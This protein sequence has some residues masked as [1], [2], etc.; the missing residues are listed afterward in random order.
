MVGLYL[1]QTGSGNSVLILHMVSPIRDLAW[2][3]CSTSPIVGLISDAISVPR[4]HDG[5]GSPV[6]FRCRISLRDV[7]RNIQ[8]GMERGNL[9]KRGDHQ[10]NPRNQILLA[11]SMIGWVP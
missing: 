9:W 1:D 11:T 6:H 10:S 8:D 5:Q 2:I 3:D 4:L 7:Y